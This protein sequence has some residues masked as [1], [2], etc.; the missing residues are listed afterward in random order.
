VFGAYHA[1]IDRITAVANAMGWKVWKMDGRGTSTWDG[2]SGEAAYAEFQDDKEDLKILYV[3]HPASGGKALTLTRSLWAAFFSNTFNGED[4]TQG[5][6]RGHRPGKDLNRGFTVW[7]FIHLPTDLLV[8]ENLLN[9]KEL[10]RVP[11][12]EIIRCL[13]A[14]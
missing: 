6:G 14:A 11:K 3:A 8:L 7:D 4:R 2:R 10:E 5:E 12:A 9:K 13:R 1:S